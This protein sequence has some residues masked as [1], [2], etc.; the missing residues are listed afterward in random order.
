MCTFFLKRVTKS[1]IGM[2]VCVVMV[3]KNIKYFFLQPLRRLFS[4]HSSYSK[5]SVINKN[6]TAYYQK[7]LR[8]FNYDCYWIGNIWIN[9]KFMRWKMFP[10]GFHPLLY[11]ILLAHHFQ[12]YQ[13]H[14]I[15]WSLLHAH[16]LF[17]LLH[18]M[19]VY[20]ISLYYS[21]FSTFAYIFIHPSQWHSR[22]NK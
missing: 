17:Y 3:A 1:I 11:W 13:S 4:L 18:F 8:L 6:F 14:S 5:Y 7:F 19:S 21:F 9:R 2:C 22:D 12:L 15:Q 16:F 10:F 20:P